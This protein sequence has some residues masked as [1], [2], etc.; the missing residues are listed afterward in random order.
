MLA[1]ADQTPR[2]IRQPASSLTSIAT[3]R[4]LDMLAP[5]GFEVAWGSIQLQR[6]IELTDRIHHMP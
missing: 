1:M 4:R 3:V 5:T 6:R 2:A